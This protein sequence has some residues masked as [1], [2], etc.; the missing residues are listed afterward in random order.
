MKA[1]AGFIVRGRGQAIL[2]ASLGGIVAFLLPPLTSFAHYFG[3]AVVALVT[4]YVSG[5]QGLLVLATATAVTVLFYQMAGMPAAAVAVTV[6]LLWLPSW[7]MALVLRSTVNLAF[8]M[9]AG[10]ALGVTVLLMVY[11]IHGD[12]GPWWLERM[13]MLMEQLQQMGVMTGE[14]SDTGGLQALS[15]LMTGIVLASLLLGA[16]CSVILARW[17]QAL[18]VNPGGLQSEFTGL[19]LGQAAAVLTL[20]VMVASR[21]AEG[22]LSDFAAQA[23][24]LLL[25]PYLFAGLAVAHGL[26]RQAGAGRGWLVALYI[27]LF[28]LPQSTLVVAGGGLLDTWMDF[29]RRFGGAGGSTDNQPRD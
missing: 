7:L 27:L 28:I 18:L 2:A 21:L 29:R 4:L 5:Q 20:L 6:L 9:L 25:V 14:L 19:R 24:L 15:G 17:W 11:A 16:I 1:L 13:Q 3:A 26:V 12:P 10:T 22:A 8:A 23:V